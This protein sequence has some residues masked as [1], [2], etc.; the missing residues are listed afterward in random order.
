M[1]WTPVLVQRG[2]SLSPG[3]S[4]GSSSQ[5]LTNWKTALTFP[6]FQVLGYSM[7]Q[8]S[9]SPCL[10][11]SH[12]LYA[13]QGILLCDQVLM[14]EKTVALTSAVHMQAMFTSGWHSPC[15]GVY[16]SLKMCWEVTHSEI[17]ASEPPITDL[18]I[19]LRPKNMHLIKWPSGLG[20][21]WRV[22]LP[23]QDWSWLG[24]GPWN[25]QSW[26]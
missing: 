14:G 16:S 11:G 22:I 10:V 13:F 8:V 5:R 1:C 17:P 19:H 2:F 4:T 6:F 26:T 25:V 24:P 18:R 9:L 20:W 12:E 23:A 21:E 15:P 3:H 7:G